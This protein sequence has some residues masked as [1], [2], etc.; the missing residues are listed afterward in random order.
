MTS[1]CEILEPFFSCAQLSVEEQR[2]IDSLSVGDASR[3]VRFLYR[4]SKVSPD[5]RAWLSKFVDFARTSD[6][7]VVEWI[8]DVLAVY[9]WLEGRNAQARVAD[10][11]EYISC[12]REG[13][14]SQPGHS[15]A[16]YLDSYGFAREVPTQ[17]P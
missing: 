17:S 7:S 12:A 6:C 14:S 1:A 10:V 15:I 8:A 13:S 5:G 11:L 2:A 3:L 4:E 16:W 9:E